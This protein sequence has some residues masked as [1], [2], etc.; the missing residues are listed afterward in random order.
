MHTKKLLVGALVLS[1]VAGGAYYYSN[2]SSLQGKFEARIK[3]KP[4]LGVTSITEVDDVLTIVV[5]N[6]GAG[7]VP[8][9][10]VGQTYIYIDDLTVPDKKYSWSTLSDKA[11]FTAGSSSTLEYGALEDG[12]YEI[13]VCVDATSVVNESDETNN[14]LTETVTFANPLPDLVADLSATSLSIS[15]EVGVDA[16]G[17]VVDADV[18]IDGQCGIKNIGDVTASGSNYNSCFFNYYS[19]VDGVGALGD[20]RLA[21]VLSLA[22]GSAI[23]VTDTWSYTYSEPPSTYVGE[24]VQELSDMG[25]ATLSVTHQTD[26]ATTKF[27]EESDETNNDE[28]ESIAVDDSGI[29][30]VL[31]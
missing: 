2:G 8:I 29:T 25:F 24:F 31:R 1:A 28:T 13:M 12:I 22:A 20:L 11:F 30:W 10:T 18:V 16:T 26:Y 23:T 17:A 15:G 27:I 14:C 21:G 5:N 6:S 7:S 3:A 4:N 19:A 9:G